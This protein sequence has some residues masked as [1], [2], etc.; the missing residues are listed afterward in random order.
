MSKLP[1][2]PSGWIVMVTAGVFYSTRRGGGVGQRT[3]TAH[4]S[5]HTGHST[6]VTAHRTAVGHTHSTAHGSRRTIT[7]QHTGHG[8]RSQHSTRVTAHGHFYP[9][10]WAPRRLNLGLMHSWMSHAGL[11]RTAKRPSG[12]SPHQS[13][14]GHS[15]VTAQSQHSRSTVTA[16]S[17]HSHSTVT[18]QSQHSRSTV[19]ATRSVSL[20]RKRRAAR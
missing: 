14:H 7:A 1:H 17:Q 5:Q 10:P 15:T 2:E 3:G 18:A 12:E 20:R 6:R 4:W 13:Q 16:Q 9:R 8:T 19:I 11:P